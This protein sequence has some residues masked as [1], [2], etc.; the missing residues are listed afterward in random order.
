MGAAW[1]K[2]IKHFQIIA[3]VE[4]AT[5]QQA[6]LSTVPHFQFTNLDPWQW[7]NTFRDVLSGCSQFVF[8]GTWSGNNESQNDEMSCE[9]NEDFRANFSTYE[10]PECWE[11][12][13]T[14]SGEVKSA[15][16][17]R[18]RICMFSCSHPRAP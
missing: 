6:N 2:F 15:Q 17:L 3:M 9:E 1:G 11:F 12:E 10:F 13:F 7:G 8:V 5:H 18:I 16:I 4:N 14:V